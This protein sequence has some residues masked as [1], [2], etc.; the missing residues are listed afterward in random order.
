[1]AVGITT[2]YPSDATNGQEIIRHALFEFD[3]GRKQH[4]SRRV[5]VLDAD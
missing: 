2:L 1:M 4:K 3:V 5:K